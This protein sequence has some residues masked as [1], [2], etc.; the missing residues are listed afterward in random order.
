MVTIMKEKFKN[1]FGLFF[2]IF[3]VIIVIGVPLGTVFAVSGGHPYS[4]YTISKEVSDHI[5]ELGYTD[6]DLLES[7]Y[8]NDTTLINDDYYEGCYQ[9][10]F[11]DE[12]EI[13][14]Y[15]GVTK[16]NHKVCQFSEKD[17]Q[18]QDGSYITNYGQ[19]HHS[20]SHQ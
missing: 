13:T 20:E 15:Y 4:M 12:P 2:T 14:Y 11:K 5:E 6:D 19:C 7:H 17:E 9:V 8:V 1:N 3:V 16:K 10:I 18:L